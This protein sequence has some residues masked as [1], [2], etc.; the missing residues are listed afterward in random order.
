MV[1]AQIFRLLKYTRI[2][3]AEI[4]RQPC[5]K[6]LSLWRDIKFE[7]AILN[8]VLFRKPISTWIYSLSQI[9]RTFAAARQGQP[10]ASRRTTTRDGKKL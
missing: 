9:S 3:P 1:S 8:F 7:T 4:G 10:T 5:Q 2:F 6:K